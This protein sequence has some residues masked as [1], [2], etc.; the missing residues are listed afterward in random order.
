MAEASTF[1]ECFAIIEEKVKPQRLRWRDVTQVEVV[2]Q[3]YGGVLAGRSRSYTMLLQLMREFL[4][5][6]RV[7]RTVAFVFVQQNQVLMRNDVCLFLKSGAF[8]LHYK[9]RFMSS[10]AGH[11]LR[12]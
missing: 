5:I 10:G 2:V 9:H 6:A 12:P 4:V 8:S 7:S 11:T 3:S 1:S